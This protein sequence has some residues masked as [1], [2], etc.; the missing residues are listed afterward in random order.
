MPTTLNIKIVPQ[1]LTTEFQKEKRNTEHTRHAN[2]SRPIVDQC[3]RKTT[4]LPRTPLPTT[5]TT[6]SRHSMPKDDSSRRLSSD[7]LAVPRSTSQIVES[8][9]LPVMYIPIT[10]NALHIYALIDSGGSMSTIDR[11]F[12]N[13]RNIR[14][15]TTTPM[16]LTLANE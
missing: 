15:H 5:E 7:R 9:S 8:A 16:N 4:K 10:P 11:S 3:P 13:T 2:L 1:K 6:P 12:P 14:Y